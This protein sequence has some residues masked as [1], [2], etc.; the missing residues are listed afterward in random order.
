MKERRFALRA[1]GAALAGL[2][3]LQHGRRRQP[4]SAGHRAERRVG[5]QLPCDAPRE[6]VDRDHRARVESGCP[7]RRSR[8]R[9]V[10]VV[11][12]HRRQPAA[13]RLGPLDEDDGVAKVL[14]EVAPFGEESGDVLDGH[15]VELFTSDYLTVDPDFEP[16]RWTLHDKQ[17]HALLRRDLPFTAE[18]D[19]NPTISEPCPRCLGRA[20]A[21]GRGHRS[22][23]L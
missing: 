3:A 14:L 5:R 4:E 11:E 13:R 2:V 6:A 10:M 20:P 15:R 16:Y 7:G 23:R 12:A 21:W 1:I 8:M 9:L 19:H 18:N 22:A 17:R